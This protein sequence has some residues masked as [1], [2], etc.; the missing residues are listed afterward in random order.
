MPTH[1]TDLAS[2]V[3]SANSALLDLPGCGPLASPLGSGRGLR[4]QVFERI[5]AQGAVARVDVAKDLGVSPASVTTI[6]ADLIEMGLIRE[7][8]LSRKDGDLGRGRPPVALGVNPGARYVAGLKLS[9]LSHAAV[10][11]DFAG[12]VVGRASVL[13]PKLNLDA[14][15]VAEEADCVLGLAL[16]DAGLDRSA[17]SAVGVGLPGLI[18]HDIGTVIW[19]PIIRERNV[20]FA[21]LLSRRL[22]L[23][24]L[25]DND[26]NLL[27]LSELWFGVGRS[28][29]TFVMVTVERGLGMG[30]VLDNALW[31]GSYGVGMEFGHIKVQLDGALCRCGQR[32]CL[33]AYVAD[34][35]LA[36]EASTALDWDGGAEGDS[37]RTLIESLYAEARAGNE[38]ARSIF[39]RAGRYLALGLATITN[40]LDPPL[41]IL[42]G[43]RM[44]YDQIYPEAA[45][46][47]M[48]GL[49]LGADRD[50]PRVEVHAWS[51]WDWARGAAAE[52]LRE[53]TD[54]LFKVG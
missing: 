42:S 21:A 15:D 49:T 30:F 41:I 4:Q 34:Y 5:R 28:L 39:Q 47:E 17:L 36:R 46:V 52:A 43:D 32:G 31:R 50:T 48:R 37:Q 16:E 26:A 25:I 53:T 1:P 6:C 29:S 18:R 54:A 27:A 13:R 2:Q 12:D 14:K 11:L 24:T 40:L 22:G 51:A 19:S 45:M 9:D 10:I 7:L 44:R 3:P 38:A 23:V 35:A 33:E 8:A 20:P